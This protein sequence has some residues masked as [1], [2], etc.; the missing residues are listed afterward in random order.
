MEM[1]VLVWVACCVCW[2]GPDLEHVHKLYDMDRII[3]LRRAVTQSAATDEETLFYQAVVEARF[4]HE[5]PAIDKL[6][7]FLQSHPGS[8]FE[9]KAHEELAGAMERLGRDGEGA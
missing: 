7:R 1:R 4:G 2:A 3:E 9:R 5:A 6:H 8:E